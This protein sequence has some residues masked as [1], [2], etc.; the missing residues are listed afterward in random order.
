MQGDHCIQFIVSHAASAPGRFGACL[1]I[2]VEPQGNECTQ[3][4]SLFRQP[5][6]RPGRRGRI[7]T[8]RALALKSL[9]SARESL[10]AHRHV[11]RWHGYKNNLQRVA[12]PVLAIPSLTSRRR[13][14]NCLH[15]PNEFCERTRAEGCD[16]VSGT[17]ATLKLRCWALLF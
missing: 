6:A 11:R 16:G 4:T 3:L 8:A 1:T 10:W 5:Q 13:F 9:F 7:P 2:T 14:N 17:D 12:T 15:Q